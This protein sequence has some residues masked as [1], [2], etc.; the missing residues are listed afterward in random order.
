MRSPG[1]GFTEGC[2]PSFGLLQEQQVL[3]NFA[4]HL[5]PLQNERYY[6]SNVGQ[7][8]YTIL[9]VVFWIEWFRI[10]RS[11]SV[12]LQTQSGSISLFQRSQFLQRNSSFLFSLTLGSTPNRNSHN[13]G[14]DKGERE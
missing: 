2:R 11:V 8:R 13:E 5:Q 6:V 12:A 10:H 9:T 3:L 4:R 7:L 14:F 1:S